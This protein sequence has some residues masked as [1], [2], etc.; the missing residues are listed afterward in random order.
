MRPA[1]RDRREFIGDLVSAA[2][3]AAVAGAG[4]LA[5]PWAALAGARLEQGKPLTLTPAQTEGPYY[6]R[7]FPSDVDNDLLKLADHKKLAD[8]ME[9]RIWG[10]VLDRFGRPL[11]G[12]SIEIWQCDDHG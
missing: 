2:S 8:G 6:P 11:A 1:R 5:T 7:R 12:A 3:F 4:L 9:A 10:R